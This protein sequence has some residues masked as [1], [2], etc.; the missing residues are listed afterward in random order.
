MNVYQVFKPDLVFFQRRADRIVRAA[1]RHGIDSEQI[2]KV[3]ILCSSAPGLG[4][5]VMTNGDR[6]KI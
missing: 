6:H 5:V 3:E 2:A 1:A 4:W